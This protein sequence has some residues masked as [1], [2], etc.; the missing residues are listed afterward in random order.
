[1]NYIHVVVMIN[2]HQLYTIWTD[3]ILLSASA[4]GQEL[5]IATSNPNAPTILKYQ[6]ALV[7]S[8]IDFYYNYLLLLM[9]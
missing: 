4:A 9:N 2:N 3:D 6:F 1:M 5:G 8:I 7:K